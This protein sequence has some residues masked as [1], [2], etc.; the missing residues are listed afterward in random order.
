MKRIIFPREVLLIEV[1]RWCGDTACKARARVA[2]TKGEA[3]AYAGFECA[4]CGRWNE[5][6][7]AE[8][9][10]PDW[11]E[12]LRVTSL[13]GLRPVRAERSEVAAGEVVE[14][15]SDAWKRLGDAEGLEDMAERD[16][17]SF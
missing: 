4:R 16:V 10:V 3:S 2:L 6:A 11:W 14:R 9:D 13:E 8:R 12:E 17:N 7:L 5:D 1:E 15:M